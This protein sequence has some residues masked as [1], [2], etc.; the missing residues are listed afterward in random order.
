MCHLLP[1]EASQPKHT[2]D[3]PEQIGSRTDWIQNVEASPAAQNVP[4]GFQWSSSPTTARISIW[5]LLWFTLEN[6]GKK[7]YSG[8]FFTGVNV[9]VQLL[10]G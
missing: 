1:W 6:P 3:E 10:Q 9:Q 7:Q 8:D 2:G 4:A 5:S